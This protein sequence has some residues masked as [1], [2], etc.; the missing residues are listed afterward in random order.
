MQRGNREESDSGGHE[1]KRGCGA[2]EKKKGSRREREKN[3]GFLF[4]VDS[5]S[6][7]A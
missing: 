4:K 5:E 2:M 3:E 7:G 1:G 6:L